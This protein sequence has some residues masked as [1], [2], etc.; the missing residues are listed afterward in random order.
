MFGSLITPS[1][2]KTV[3]FRIENKTR[4]LFTYSMGNQKKRIGRNGE[5]EK[6][7]AIVQT[8]L[9]DNILRLTLLNIVKDKK[10]HEDAQVGALKEKTQF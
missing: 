8:T 3:V 7:Y 6:L 4:F 1:Q 2:F 10:K 5:R 9:K